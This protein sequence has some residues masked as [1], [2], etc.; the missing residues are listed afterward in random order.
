VNPYLVLAAILGGILHGL[1]AKPD[2]QPALG[3]KDTSTRPKLTHD[4]IA[5]IEG[6]AASEV[7]KEI[8]GPTFHHVFT[9]IKRDEAALL[10][11]IIPPFEYRAYL[12]RL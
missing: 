6:F 12:S 2:L 7:A 9:E 1:E 10:T 3:P 11:R 4:W 5:A 8:F